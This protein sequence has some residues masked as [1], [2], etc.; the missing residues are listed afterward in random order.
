MLIHFY[1]VNWD[2]E[3]EVGSLNELGLETDFIEDV[4]IEDIDDDELD[5]FLSDWLSDEYGYCHF[6]FDYEIIED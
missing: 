6:G 5:D 4:D 3:E 1:N 2:V